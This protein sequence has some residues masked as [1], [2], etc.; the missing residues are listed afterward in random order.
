MAEKRKERRPGPAGGKYRVC[1]A[2]CVIVRDSKILMQKRSFG[3]WKGYWGLIGGKVDVGETIIHAAVR[4]AKEESCLDVRK[5]NMLGIYDAK[6]R[7]PEQ[8]GIAIGFLCEVG[9]GEPRMSSEATDMKW[10]GFD[11]IPEKLAF[12]HRLIIEDA[13]KF[14]EKVKQ[15]KE[16]SATE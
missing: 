8:H 14:L 1:A 10:F 5:L 7:D 16:S 6:D 13:R 9:E 2:D 15:L 3:M 12:D 11:E 4:E